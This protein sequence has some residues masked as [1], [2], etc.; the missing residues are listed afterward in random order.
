MPIVPAAWRGHGFAGPGS[1]NGLLVTCGDAK[2]V[3]KKIKRQ[4]RFILQALYDLN[5]FS[6]FSASPRSLLFC[7][8]TARPEVEARQRGVNPVQAFAGRDVQGLAVGA[9]EF[10]VGGG[11]RGGDGRQ[12][13]SLRRDDV[14]AAPCAEPAAATIRPSVVT[15]MP[16]M[17]R[18][19]P[20]SRIT[21]GWETPPSESRSSAISARRRP[22]LSAT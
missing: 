4:L 5:V 3:A 1:L 7:L 10:H 9:A 17:P 12:D 6:T 22:P 21:R 20:K 13:L 2:D 8:F 16:S 18:L 15:V 11:F 19:S 14:D